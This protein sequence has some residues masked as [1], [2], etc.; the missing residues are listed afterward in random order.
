MPRTPLTGRHAKQ[1]KRVSTHSLLH[2]LSQHLNNGAV[3][4]HL[5]YEVTD[6]LLQQAFH[7]KS[8]AASAHRHWQVRSKGK[9]CLHLTQ[10][11][12]NEVADVL[13]HAGRHA[14]QVEKV[15]TQQQFI[16]RA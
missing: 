3:R 7:S 14:Q 4:Q 12:K 16:V 15:S 6:V 1:V 8:T 11:L 9:H 13:L 5:K 2:E 10:H